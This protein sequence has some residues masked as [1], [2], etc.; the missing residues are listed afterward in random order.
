MRAAADTQHTAAKIVASSGNAVGK[1]AGRDHERDR[2][3]AFSKTRQIIDRLL[4]LI[5]GRKTAPA[6]AIT[7]KA[8]NAHAVGDEAGEQERGG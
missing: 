4:P 6:A 1:Q 8:R 5:G 3:G 2:L 7:E